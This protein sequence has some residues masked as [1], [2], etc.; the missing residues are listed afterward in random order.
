M[1]IISCGLPKSASTITHVYTQELVLASGIRNGQNK[2]NKIFEEGYVHHLGITNTLRLLFIH[3]FYGNIVVKTHT[4]PSPF[5]KLLILLKIA[6][7]TYT[8]RDPRDIILSAIDHGKKSSDNPFIKY[9]NINNT[10]QDVIIECKKWKKWKNYGKALFI[11][12]ENITESTI[13]EL[14]AMTDYLGFNISSNKIS[15]IVKKYELNKNVNKNFNKG[16][17][18]RYLNEMTKEELAFCNSLLE[19]YIVQ[20][21]YKL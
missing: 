19:K 9:T 12:Y 21:G 6:K 7:A 14:N 2:L 5:V 17:T 3:A 15:Q 8:T 16:T 10:L 11:T 18:K 1:I 20:L 4:S 13:N